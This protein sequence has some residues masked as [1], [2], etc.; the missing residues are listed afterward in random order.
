M[1]DVHRLH[2][3]ADLRIGFDGG[4]ARLT[5]SGQ[6]LL[7]S[8][9]SP[10]D[11]LRAGPVRPSLRLVTTLAEQL[12][13]AGLRLDVAS[14]RGCLLSMGAGVRSRVLGFGRP[15]P[16]AIGS[17][18]ALAELALGSTGRAVRAVARRRWK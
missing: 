14:E 15:R 10:V 12:R 9:P 17:L 6:R 18:V 8:V 4:T 1:T 5:G 7:L 16:V 3:E 13:D 2:V 11:A